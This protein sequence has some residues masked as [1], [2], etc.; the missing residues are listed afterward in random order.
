MVFGV[1]V[2]LFIEDLR[3]EKKGNVGSGS[4]VF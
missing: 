2:Q 1:E 4:R 3:F